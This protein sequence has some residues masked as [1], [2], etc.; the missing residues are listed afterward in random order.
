M[1]ISILSLLSQ[2]PAQGQ[3]PVVFNGT[4]ERT[5]NIRLHFTY[6]TYVQIHGV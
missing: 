6:P 4:L 3:L 2:N 1:C 5:I